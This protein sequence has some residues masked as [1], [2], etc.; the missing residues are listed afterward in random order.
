MIDFKDNLAIPR[1]EGEIP[2]V[3][4]TPQHS[5]T[6]L[7]QKVGKKALAAL[8]A[9]LADLELN[10]RQYLFLVL[11]ASGDSISQYAL[12]KKLD[13]DPTILVKLIDQLE[14]RGL[15]ERS[16]SEEDR[17]RHELTLTKA[18]KQLLQQARTRELRAEREVTTAIG[19][20]REELRELL[21]RAALG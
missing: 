14:E 1:P 16:R 15:V 4:G 20:Q 11:T 12:A 9:E 18:G 7:L 10:S 8:D 17:R 3:M 13:V 2:P 5:L 6:Y 19:D 21:L